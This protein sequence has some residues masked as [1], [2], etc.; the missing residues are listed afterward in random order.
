[1]NWGSWS[2]FFSMRGAGLYVWGSYGV[3]LALML[4]EIALVRQRH[5]AALQ[6]LSRP[7]GNP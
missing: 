2:E 5:R 6:A 4:T 7:A 1:M 3:T